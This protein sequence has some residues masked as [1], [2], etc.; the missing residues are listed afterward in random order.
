MAV[1][2]RALVRNEGES[3]VGG[4]GST[5]DTFVPGSRSGFLAGTFRG[6]VS[7]HGEARGVVTDA[8]RNVG[9]HVD[10]QLMA[11]VLILLLSL[12]ELLAEAENLVRLL[13]VLL[14]ESIQ[15]LM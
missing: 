9:V 12:P 2:L 10:G 14:D 13:M 7:V 1:A 4:E 5:C 11:E 15:L 8:R 6:W 3:L